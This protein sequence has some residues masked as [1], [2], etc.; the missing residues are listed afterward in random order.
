[1]SLV[2]ST[3]DPS[4]G[5]SKCS[6]LCWSLMWIKVMVKLAADTLHLAPVVGVISVWAV[7]VVEKHDVRG[8]C[9][10]SL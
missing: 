9:H 4:T 2:G 5:P 3:R 1:M 10:D 7:D 6:L 8:V